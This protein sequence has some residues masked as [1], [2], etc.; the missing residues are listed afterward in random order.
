MQFKVN[1]TVPSSE[2]IRIAGMTNPDKTPNHGRMQD[3]WI[4]LT[5]G[6]ASKPDAD[7]ESDEDKKEKPKYKRVSA[8]A[9]DRCAAEIKNA[10][11]A[12]VLGKTVDISEEMRDFGIALMRW[13]S[14]RL[15]RYPLVLAEEE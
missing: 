9:L 13:A 15:K 8:E 3:A 6:R 12:L 2:F 5:G 10:E 4:I 11:S 1:Q 14:G 7:K